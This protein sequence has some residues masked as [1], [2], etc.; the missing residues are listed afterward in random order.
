MNK[1]RL[2]LNKKTAKKKK[3]SPV[4]KS[5][6]TGKKLIPKGVSGNPNGRP[7]GTKNKFTD[8]KN[9]FLQVFDKL[10]GVEGFF[11]W[12]SKNNLNKT[13]FYH[14]ITKL[15]PKTV[16][17]NAGD[18]MVEYIKIMQQIF[19]KAENGAK[20]KKRWYGYY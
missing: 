6:G 10:G 17:V 7:K 14:M 13:Q 12:A 15:L 4:K 8:L 20:K 11:Q 16:D 1:W 2:Q 18:S 3:L 9:A 5:K 19:N